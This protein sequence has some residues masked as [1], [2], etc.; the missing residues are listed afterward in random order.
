MVEANSHESPEPAHEYQTAS[1]TDEIDYAAPPNASRYVDPGIVPS[2]SAQSAIQRA[3]E[4]LLPDKQSVTGASRT[5]QA[6]LEDNGAAVGDDLQVSFPPKHSYLAYY[7][8]DE[9]PPARRPADI[10]LDSLRSVPVGTPLEEIKRAADA[11]GLN[12][13][14]MKTVAKIEFRFQSEAAYRV[15]HRPIPAQPL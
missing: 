10:V 12:Y 4:P 11:F 9:H 8:Y 2:A 6:K 3:P 14:F 1:A 15:V 7:V 5:E 13:N